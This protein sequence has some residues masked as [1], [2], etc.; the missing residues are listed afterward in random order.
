MV[1]LIVFLLEFF[2][3]I[4]LFIYLFIYLSIYLFIHL[5]IYL[6]IYCQILSGKLICCWNSKNLH[7]LFYKCSLLLIIIMFL[8]KISFS[9]TIFLSVSRKE[10]QQAFLKALFWD[11]YFSTFLLMIFF[12]F[13]KVQACKLRFSTMYSPKKNI[14]NIT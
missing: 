2:F 12:Y 8:L 6:F 11:H 5:F 7:R 10:F 9:L 13:F 3:T 4:Y 1:K 14:K